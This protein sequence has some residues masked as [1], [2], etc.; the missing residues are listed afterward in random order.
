MY[1]QFLIKDELTVNIEDGNLN[2]LKFRNKKY[3]QYLNELVNITD[4]IFKYIHYFYEENEYLHK[5]SRR[6]NKF[7]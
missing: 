4:Q 2:L 1:F 7:H 6:E 3:S 5:K